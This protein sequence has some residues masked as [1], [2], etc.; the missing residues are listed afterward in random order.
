MHST[1]LHMLSLC[2]RMQL[3]RKAAIQ[4]CDALQCPA[5]QHLS[6]YPLCLPHASGKDVTIKI[7]KKKPKKGGKP[8]TKPQIKT[9]KVD[10]WRGGMVWRSW[11]VHLMH[12]GARLK[13][14]A[15]ALLHVWKASRASL[16]EF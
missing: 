5:T 13:M 3:L 14:L 8:D 16:R 7:M 11:G 6:P 1:A 15:S 10:V 9:E 4:T 12:H 2:T